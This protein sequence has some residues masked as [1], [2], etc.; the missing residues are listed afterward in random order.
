MFLMN[1]GCRA[2]NSA[3]IRMCC[4]LWRKTTIYWRN[5]EHGGVITTANNASHPR[6]SG[7]PG[8]Y[9]FVGISFYVQREITNNSKKFRQKSL[10][11]KLANHK[12]MS[13]SQHQIF[14]DIDW[15]VFTFIH[16]AWDIW[17]ANLSVTLVRK[18]ETKT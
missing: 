12:S 8:R 9:I 6:A 11:D 16:I 13:P 14:P 4:K 2:A 17:Y 7:T 18:I 3:D 5:H 10:N 15:I 1:S